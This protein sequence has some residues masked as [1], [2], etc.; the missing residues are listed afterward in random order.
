M[1]VNPLIEAQRI[2]SDVQHRDGRAMSRFNARQWLS[3]SNPDSSLTCPEMR[4]LGRSSD[5]LA[6]GTGRILL[7]KAGDFNFEFKGKATDLKEL[8]EFVWYHRRHP[9][10]GLARLRLTVVD[11]SGRKLHCG[12]TSPEAFDLDKNADLKCSGAFE[13]LML[14]APCFAEIGSE[15][16]IVVPERHWLSEL[17][18]LLFPPPDMNGLSKHSLTLMG[19]SLDFEYGRKSRTLAIGVTGG[20]AFPQTYAETWLSEPL[21]MMLGQL[22]FPRIIVRANPDRALVTI[23]QIR[24]WHRQGNL[25]SMLDPVAAV[26]KPNH[27]FELYASLLRFVATARNSDGKPNF[28]RHPLTIF[29]EE[30]AQAM[31][32]SRW[33]MTLTLASA[34]EGALDL[35]FPS[36]SRDETVKSVELKDLKAHIDRWT[37]HPSSTT[38]SILS[39]KNLAK[40]G[41]GRAADLTAMKR[42]RLLAARKIVS[43]DEV[44]AWDTVRNKV[45]H[46]KVFSPFSSEENDKLVI[47]LMILFRRIA[48]QIAL[49]GGL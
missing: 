9:Y 6:S 30:L 37:G 13:G 33:I 20:D 15:I 48:S 36:G 3:I 22:A 29:C 21:R 34:V 44:D 32:G 16:L 1:K 47:N 11:S 19:S 24:G 43:A 42:L 5:V 18:P 41:V 28:D 12:Y 49:E 46:G 39:L 25:F 45:A 31:R 2:D 4:L 14:D 40:Q 35:L 26:E 23:S 17:L 8:D 27:F 38:E 10:D 7:D